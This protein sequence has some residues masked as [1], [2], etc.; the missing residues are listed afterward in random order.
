MA[1]EHLV[2]KEHLGH[3]FKENNMPGIFDI[4][5]RV[6]EKQGFA[7]D[8]AALQRFQQQQQLALNFPQLA[9][10][11]V[12]PNV[13]IAPQFPRAQSLAGGELFSN[14]LLQQQQLRG[15]QVAPTI[16]Q[17]RAAEATRIGARPGTRRFERIATGPPKP[18][19][20][21]SSS[22]QQIADPATGQQINALV[23]PRTGNIIKKF[24]TVEEGLSAKDKVQV[25]VTQAK[26]FR[27]DPRIKNLNIVERSERGMQAALKMATAPGVKSRIAS[28]Q[29]LG[30]LF[31][32]MLDPESVVR[33]SEFARTPEGAAAINRLLAIAPQL[34]LGGLRLLDEDR[35]ALVTMAQK[36]L[37]EAKITANRA[38]DEF[39]T[40][41]DEIGLNKKIVFG[42][43]KR[44][45]IPKD[46]QSTIPASLQAIPFSPEDIEAE[47][48]RR[49]AVK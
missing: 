42:G 4:F 22:F 43:A 40:R 45:D 47:L 6:R 7:Q 41:A 9:Q 21:V 39:E 18:I 8:V 36:L 35:Q 15:W 26:E 31:Q 49:G 2:R 12:G 19:A 30:V 32:K 23:N 10:G 16:A 28:D 11:Q 5:A 44:F 14:F 20:P 29:A 24:G 1:L 46:K 33:E 34:R 13:S 38:F 37:Q 27:A 17:Q 48:R 25:A 3:S